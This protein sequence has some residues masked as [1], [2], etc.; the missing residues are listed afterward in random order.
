VAEG[1]ANYTW[2][3]E[4]QTWSEDA[5]LQLTMRVTFTL[6]GEE[7]SVAASTLFDPGASDE[8]VEAAPID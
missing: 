1:E 2:N 3:L 7:F 8:P 5:M 6:Q 4:T